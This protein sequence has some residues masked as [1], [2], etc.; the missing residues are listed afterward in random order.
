MIKEHR[1]FTLPVDFDCILY[2]YTDFRKFQSLIKSKSLYFSR[3][4]LLGDKFEGSYS[5]PA[6]EFRNIMYKDASPEFREKGLSKWSLDFIKASFVNCWQSDTHES[7]AMWQFYSKFKKPIVIKS[8]IHKLRSYILDEKT[9]FLLGFVKYIDYKNDSQDIGNM[10]SQLF[11]KRREHRHEQEFRII[12][13][14]LLLLNQ[15]KNESK[16]IEKG[17]FIP[18]D[19]QNLIESIIISPYIDK[20]SYQEIENYL[21][22]VSLRNKLQKSSLEDTP[23]F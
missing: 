18:I 19:I 13:A 5:K 14:R 21:S 12:D 3:A 4:D 1:Q 23:H 2:R 9:E 22:K 8:S 7:E 15:Y 17:V 6:I 11:Y 20:S 16:K 10:F